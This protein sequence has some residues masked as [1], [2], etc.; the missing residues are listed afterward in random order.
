[1]RDSYARRGTRTPQT[2]RRDSSADIKA[3]EGTDVSDRNPLSAAD[4]VSAAR[5]YI[6]ALTGKDLCGVVSL[7]PVDDGWVVGV[8]VV[9][10]RRIPSSNDML[11]LYRAR[12]GPDG[13]LVRYGRVRRYLRGRGDSIDGSSR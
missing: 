10:D 7:E 9:E 13:S 11:G 5:E 1:M 2:R 8:E 3:Y 12:L 6:T 4:V